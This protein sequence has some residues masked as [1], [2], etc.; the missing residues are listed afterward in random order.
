MLLCSF[1]F[2]FELVSCNEMKLEFNATLVF[3]SILLDFV[4]RFFGPHEFSFCV[5]HCVHHESRAELYLQH[6]G[7]SCSS[8]EAK[9]G[10]A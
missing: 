2:F 1:I 7:K 3:Y 10:M 5:R 6:D 9:G 8:A 4:K